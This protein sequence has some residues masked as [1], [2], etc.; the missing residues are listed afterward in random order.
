MLQQNQPYPARSWRQGTSQP[1][2]AGEGCSSGD[3][4]ILEIQSPSTTFRTKRPENSTALRLLR[5][6]RR[7]IFRCSKLVQSPYLRH[8]F[9]RGWKTAS[10]HQE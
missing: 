8:S 3:L 4:R 6:R 1:C 5:L 2:P 7:H 10:R 9:P